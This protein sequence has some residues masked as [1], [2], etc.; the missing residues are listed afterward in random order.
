MTT[1]RC[2]A[3]ERARRSAIALLLLLAVTVLGTA[4]A[5]SPVR[6]IHEDAADTHRRLIRSALSHNELSTFSQT[7]LL[8]TDLDRLYAHDPEKALQ[9]LHDIAVSG[10]G[11]PNHLFAVAEA[12]FLH[13][14]RTGKRSYYLAAAVY[15]WTYL[16]PE[17]KSEAPNPFDPRFGLAASL[18]NRGLTSALE[19]DEGRKVVLRGGIFPLPF[20]EM[21]I[22]F[23]PGQLTWQGRGMTTFTPV[24][25][26]RVVGLQAYY[27]EPGLGAPLAASLT[28]LPDES[29][30]DLLLPELTIGVTAILRLPGS[31]TGLAWPP[32]EGTLEVHIPEITSTVDVAGQAVPLESEPT[33]VFAYSLADSPIWGQEYTR[34]FEALS[35]GSDQSQLYAT[36]PHRRGRIPVV[37]VH[38]TASSFGRW[39]EMYNRLASDPRLRARYEFWFFSYDSG[40]P[41]T[42]SAMLLRESLQ[43]AVRTL[44][45][46]GTDPGIRQMVVIGHSQGGLLTKMTAI[47]SGS[48]F[49]DMDFRRPLDSLDVSPDTRD[50]LRRSLF[51][52]PLPFVTRVMF[53]ATPHHGSEL[54]AGRIARWVIGFI[55]A[56]LALAGVMADVARN[57]DAMILTKADAKPRLPTSLDQ[58]NPRN[59]FLQTL[60]SIPIAPGVIA[61][62]IVAVNGDGPV[63]EGSDGFVAYKSAHI[64]G[65][66][67]EAVVRSSHSLQDNPET[68]EEVRRIL[69]LHD[70]SNVAR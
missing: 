5:T 11:G 67:S 59:R 33:A 10:S 46:A 56:P 13:A 40:S 23:D 50:L 9:Q 27:R 41:I 25:E 4:C 29:Q 21:T 6:V 15:A 7:V 60:A 43:R 48:R 32:L 8:E 3:T 34:F 28:P 61:N 68:V 54:S 17:D 57:P 49:W 69:L 39:A 14:E 66:E 37:F 45:P 47:D 70:T 44:D 16:F 18:Y 19:T 12:S 64:D 58:M 26:Y 1:R 42:W 52:K 24:A 2:R 55:K 20:G 51:V 63:E 38:G 31:R 36:V 62:S 30:N 22:T 65:V 35:F 53:L